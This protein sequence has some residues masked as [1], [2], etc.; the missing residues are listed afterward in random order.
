MKHYEKER[1]SKN[2]SRKTNHEKDK[3]KFNPKPKIQVHKT[4]T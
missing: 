2:M 1:Q 3:P 4:K